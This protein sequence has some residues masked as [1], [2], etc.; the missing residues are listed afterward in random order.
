[1][2]GLHTDA[3]DTN[4]TN[5]NNESDQTFQTTAVTLVEPEVCETFQACPEFDDF[6][7]HVTYSPS[8]IQQCQ[9]YLSDQ[10]G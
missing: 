1:M 2:F 5:D 9:L 6:L 10:L 3:N 4:D 8:E 7:P